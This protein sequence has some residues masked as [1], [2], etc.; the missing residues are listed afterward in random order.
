MNFL[1]RL[2]PVVVLILVILDALL[3]LGFGEKGIFKGFVNSA[4]LLSSGI[5]LAQLP[6]LYYIVYRAYIGPI[7]KL[8][9][10]IS[11]FMT[12]IDEEPVLEANAW[13][14][15]MNY[16][17]SF[18]IKSLQILRIFKK[19]LRE[20]RQL[21]TEVEIAS[22][23]QKN[24]M[25]D[26]ES[27]VPS[28]E[29]AL[30][31]NPASEVGGD[32]LGIISGV[33]DNYFM[34]V[35][36]VTGHGVPSGLVMMM[37]NALVSAFVSQEESSAKVLSETN[38]ILKPRIRQNMMMSAVMLRW[39]YKEKALYY[40]GAGHEFILLY[41]KR[42]NK[43]FKIKT[44]G[45]AL[46][47]MRDASKL[48]KEQQIR[49]EPGDIIILYTDGV[50]EARYRSEQNG[51]LFGIDK[52]VESILK[53]AEKSADNIFRQITIDLSAHMGY[54]HKQFDDISL[55]IAR[56]APGPGSTNT[57]AHDLIDQ[58]NITEWNWGRQPIVLIPQIATDI[59]T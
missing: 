44:G 12:G 49:F 8:N 18:F 56:Y 59:S 54:K 14:K 1:H 25:A 47:M 5:I 37:V 28:L 29:I 46:G 16:V 11:R 24:V 45:V 30:A 51:L 48:Y 2:L 42:E 6:I 55:F 23:I 34:Y 53:V 17:I 41:S 43:V 7:Q 31:S 36:D 35:G 20:G 19:E 9:Q 33:D 38:R 15:G 22:E 21:R 26:S 13:S 52:M 32:S 57:A 10:S 39:D 40:T 27:I 50:T 4:P 3:L 58:S